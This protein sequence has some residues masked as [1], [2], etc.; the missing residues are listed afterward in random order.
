M[1]F[2][3]KQ[4]QETQ[5]NIQ[6]HRGSLCPKEVHVESITS[7][8]MNPTLPSPQASSNH[9]HG[10]APAEGKQ[11]QPPAHSEPLVIPQCRQSVP[12]ISRL[13]T[14]APT[15]ISLCFPLHST[16]LPDALLK[17]TSGERE[18]G[19]GLLD[20]VKSV[21]RILYGQTKFPFFSSRFVGCSTN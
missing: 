3:P 9:R 18:G 5:G 15:P 14:G 21:V 8:A 6:G 19:V 11:C 10:Q 2:Y 4:K 7:I 12:Y 13:E 1:D 16:N 17:Q 20:T